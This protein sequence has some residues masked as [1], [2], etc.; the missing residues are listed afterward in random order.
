MNKI[1]N[2]LFAFLILSCSSHAIDACGRDGASRPIVIGVKRS[3]QENGARTKK[4]QRETHRVKSA[5]YRVNPDVSI[6]WSITHLPTTENTDFGSLVSAEEILAK[7]DNEIVRKCGVPSRLYDANKFYFSVQKE[8][9]IVDAF[10]TISSQ[11]FEKKDGELSIPSDVINKQLQYF[12]NA[13]GDTI[14][15]EFGSLDAPDDLIVRDFIMRLFI[16]GFAISILKFIRHENISITDAVNINHDFSNDAFMLYKYIPG[17][18][19]DSTFEILSTKP[20][21]KNSSNRPG[22]GSMTTDY[23]MLEEMLRTSQKKSSP[24]LFERWSSDSRLHSELVTA[25]QNEYFFPN[26]KRCQRPVGFTLRKFRHSFL[27]HG[28]PTHFRALT[29]PQIESF[30]TEQGLVDKKTDMAMFDSSIGWLDR[31]LGTML[32][33]QGSAFNSYYG[34]DPNPIVISKAD[35]LVNDLALAFNPNFT[36]SFKCAA[37]E[38]VGSDVILK[39]HGRHFDRVVTSPPF[40]HPMEC[41][42]E[43]TPAQKDQA[44]NRYKTEQAFTEN[45]LAKIILTNMELLTA[46]GVFVLHFMETGIL[47]NALKFI[48]DTHGVDIEACAIGNYFPINKKSEPVYFFQRQNRIED[49]SCSITINELTETHESNEKPSNT[50]R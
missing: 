39:E 9:D 11:T 5:N 13:L 49:P 27:I 4:N 22:T 10:T 21:F 40:F 36:S 15:S 25:L 1:S 46:G 26:I 41:Y 6:S 35:E 42:A 29:I 24:T 20:Q 16:R 34:I 12:Q 32:C 30:L 50:C 8:K 3:N 37:A 31:L 38:D 47:E 17:K 23:Y 33:Y 43:G 2:F 28:H 44:W 7:N 19:H 14:V 48:K 18:N 45:F